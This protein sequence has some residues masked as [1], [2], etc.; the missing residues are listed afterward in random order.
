[1]KLCRNAIIRVT[2]PGCSCDRTA[3]SSS[4]Q[5]VDEVP[6]PARCEDDE[7]GDVSSGGEHILY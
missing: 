1:M 3:G 7:I 6:G 4:P 2:D 5:G